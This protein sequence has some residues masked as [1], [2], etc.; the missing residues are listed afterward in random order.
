VTPGVG[1]P[2]KQ[3][4]GRGGNRGGGRPRKPTTDR[5]VNITISV[6][7]D[8]LKEIEVRQRLG[9]SRGQVVDMAFAALK[10]GD[11][12]AREAW[13]RTGEK[14]QKMGEGGHGETE[15]GKN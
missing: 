9:F 13:D 14:G 2:G 4:P 6:R 5:T 11:G 1:T 8:T 12:P 3:R 7:P 10:E 15:S